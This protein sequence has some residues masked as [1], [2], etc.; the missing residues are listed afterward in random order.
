LFAIMAAT[1]PY[2]TRPY[3]LV[4]YGATG[5][6]G[7]LVS[8]YL[9]R[10]AP[11]N[12]R[13]AVAGRDEA[14]LRAIRDEVE[15][16]RASAPASS[17]SSSSPLPAVGLVVGSGP[18]IGAVSSA[19]RVV[20]TTAG[21]FALVG[22]PLLAAC[23]RDGTDYFDI[24]G[25]TL[26]VDAMMR[27]YGEEAKRK[28]VIVV[29]CSGFDSVP[30]DLGTFFA[31]EAAR[32]LYGARVSEVTGY[33][34][35]TLGVSGGT[36]ASAL[37]MLGDKSAARRAMSPFFLAGFDLPQPAPPVAALVAPLP[38]GRSPFYVALFRQYAALFVMAAVNT[39]IVRR[40]AALFGTSGAALAAH[41]GSLH[42]VS[43]SAPASATSVTAAAA[44]S[45]TPFR[46]S[47]YMLA[48][49]AFSAWT[50][51]L[52]L[53]VFGLL[54]SVPGFLTLARR[55]LPKPGEGPGASKRARSWFH[56]YLVARTE[57]AQ[58]RTIVAR[59]RGGD[60]GYEE[61]AKMLAEAGI[62]CALQRADLPGTA[63]GGGFLT[64]S[65]AMGK[66]LLERLGRANIVFE[67]LPET[68]LPAALKDKRPPP[69]DTIQAAAIVDERK[70]K[71]AEGSGGADGLRAR[72]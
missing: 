60:G 30:A 33:V 47:E 38:D 8:L 3:D 12:L 31:A 5:F 58:P 51:T 65:T 26:Y 32:K 36:I 42:P 59:V 72:L 29:P 50:M 14:K 54:S 7:R 70:K 48:P 13:W 44:Y 1:R 19:A 61:T 45:T 62:A 49:T 17:S 22:E 25:E 39:R 23:I 67:V 66:V 35:A 46:Y 40:S 64:P 55:W 20:I 6:T 56:Y 68:A 11:A 34:A 53:A 63:L 10:A 15:G 37:N 16:V 4:I 43:A 41:P 69:K 2:A 9:A 71:A 52:T 21:P 27:K 24:T 57:E 18:T 28:G